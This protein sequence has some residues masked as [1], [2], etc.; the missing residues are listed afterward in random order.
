VFTV[1]DC[2]VSSRETLNQLFP[3]LLLKKNTWLL[4]KH[5]KS[6]WLIGLYA[7]LCGDDSCIN[8]FYDSQSVYTLLKIKYS[9]R[10]ASTSMP[11]PLCER[12]G[13]SRYTEGMQN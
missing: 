2:D 10:G 9:M 6:L 5:V 7:E 8:L 12:H 1:G 4:R 3:N 13:R 11:I